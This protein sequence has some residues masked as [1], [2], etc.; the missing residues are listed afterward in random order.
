MS[1][2]ARGVGNRHRRR[3]VSRTCGRG[4]VVYASGHNH[5]PVVHL[6]KKIRSSP[7]FGNVGG[8][9]PR[10]ILYCMRHSIGIHYRGTSVL[11]H[12]GNCLEYFPV[13]HLRTAVRFV[14]Q[15]HPRVKYTL[16][17]ILH[18]R[19][20]KTP[21]EFCYCANSY[22]PPLAHRIHR[23]CARP[24]LAIEQGQIDSV[25]KNQVTIY[26]HCFPPYGIGMLIGLVVEGL[27][28]FR[29]C[30]PLSKPFIIPKYLSS[31]RGDQH[32][33]FFATELIQQANRIVVR[34]NRVGRVGDRHQVPSL[35]PD[36]TVRLPAEV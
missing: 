33:L 16:F 3:S 6:T 13:R 4:D 10:R 24:V 20:P 15:I 2:V 22:Y 36:L 7:R 9:S 25:V 1:R 18:V 21:I 26:G 12:N 28:V 14:R 30:N 23:K 29:N 8:K 31:R 19:H 35:A 27:Q 5:L 17:K 11:R 34:Q 32:F